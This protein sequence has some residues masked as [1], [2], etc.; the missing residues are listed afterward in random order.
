MIKWV[1]FQIPSHTSSPEYRGNEKRKNSKAIFQSIFYPTDN[2]AFQNYSPQIAAEEANLP[3][4]HK[5]YLS[6]LRSS[7]C[8]SL[9]SYSERIGLIPSAICPFCGGKRHTTV[10]VFFLRL[11]Y[12]SPERENL[13]GTSA[14]NVGVPFWSPSLSSPAS[15][16]P[17]PP[18]SNEHES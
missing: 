10:H 11:A 15:C 3:R 17:E 6:Q 4:P 18:S 14:P 1:W 13:I 8:S 7:S 2:R 12:H 16:S 5:T 9:H